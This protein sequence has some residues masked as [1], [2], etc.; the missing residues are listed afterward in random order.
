MVNLPYELVFHQQH[1]SVITLV[2]FRLEPCVFFWACF[3]T[4]SPGKLVPPPP[5]GLVVPCSCS[6][7]FTSCIPR[8]VEPRWLKMVP[9][10]SKKLPTSWK[11]NWTSSWAI[12]LHHRLPTAEKCFIFTYRKFCHG[13]FPNLLLNVLCKKYAIVPRATKK[14]KKHELSPSRL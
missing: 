10:C 1:H 9:T 2:T 13:T 7:C 3:E 6:M 14:I 5:N 12:C 11:M 4:R 8:I